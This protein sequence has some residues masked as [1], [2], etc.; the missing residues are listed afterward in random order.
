MSTVPA[1]P[2]SQSQN[3]NSNESIENA[4]VCCVACSAGISILGLIA[5]TITWIVYAIIGLS[6]VSDATI[7]DNYNGS[8]LWRYVLVMTIFICLQ[9]SQANNKSEKNEAPICSL[10]LNFLLMVGFASWGSYEIWGRNY[11]NS[12]TDYLIYKC[13][14][15]MVIYQWALSVLILLVIFVVLLGALVGKPPKK[16]QTTSLKPNL[17]V[18][19]SFK[20]PIPRLDDEVV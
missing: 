15:A 1:L 7:R 11:K 17:R 19:T 14:H 13:S 6:Q 9:A 16:E 5:C 20:Q 4:K 3:K 2:A 12:L 10:I 18:D 8:L